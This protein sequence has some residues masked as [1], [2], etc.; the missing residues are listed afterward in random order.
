MQNPKILGLLESLGS[1]PESKEIGLLNNLEQIMVSSLAEE[2]GRK[3][4]VDYLARRLLAGSTSQKPITQRRYLTALTIFLQRTAPEQIL[5]LAKMVEIVEEVANPK[6]IVAK[7][8]KIYFQYTYTAALFTLLVAYSNEL[9]FGEE[10]AVG[11]AQLLEG[12]ISKIR[13]LLNID[14]S[15][16]YFISGNISLLC[17]KL[18]SY[19]LFRGQAGQD[20]ETPTTAATASGINIEGVLVKLLEVLSQANLE[21]S[22]FQNAGLYLSMKKASILLARQQEESNSE[23][24]VELSETAVESIDSI[25]KKVLNSKNMIGYL[26]QNYSEEKLNTKLKLPFYQEVAEVV[27][28]EPEL[29]ID[30]VCKLMKAMLNNMEKS[31]EMIQK[32][33]MHFNLFFAE[34][35][36]YGGS[37]LLTLFGDIEAAFQRHLS[38]SLENSRSDIFIRALS[39][40][41]KEYQAKNSYTKA[42]ARQVEGA[43][44]EIFQSLSSK[45]ESN[46]RLYLIIL[47][48]MKGRP[49]GGYSKQKKTGLSEI[50]LSGLY[51]NNKIWGEYFELLKSEIKGA[52]KLSAVNYQI[53]ELLALSQ[54]SLSA[55]ALKANTKLAARAT[56]CRLKVL[57][58]FMRIYLACANEKTLAEFLEMGKLLFTFNTL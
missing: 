3:E 36:R 27:G 56:R 53:S 32:K 8:E 49:G 30:Q 24:Q 28:L 23:D 48:I 38:E 39:F 6:N 33:A 20:V 17:R 13:N 37:T 25:V 42:S 45:D 41:M 57:N 52:N 2:E 4:F 31:N 51:Q 11:S 47:K 5:P 12:V 10:A 16:S 43:F 14:K 1:A 29:H 9:A 44:S 22:L 26:R 55:K 19:Q 21:I 58:Y 40:W 50:L 54:V 34:I 35:I 46:L 18:S 15:Y 7:G